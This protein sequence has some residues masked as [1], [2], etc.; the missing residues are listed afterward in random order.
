MAKLTP[1]DFAEQQR[2]YLEKQKT[3]GADVVLRNNPPDLIQPTPAQ[4]ESVGIR[5]T[6]DK[7]R[8]EAE[9]R[10]ILADMGASPSTQ[11]GINL[12]AAGAHL[13]ARG[14]DKFQG[15]ADKHDT[16]STF[17][18]RFS[19]VTELLLGNPA[20][21]L[22]RPQQALYAGAS[23]EGWDGVK[24]RL[25]PEV[26]KET[27][28]TQNDPDDNEFQSTWAQLNDMLHFGVKALMGDEGAKQGLADAL[29][30]EPV[31]MERAGQGALSIT[32][33]LDN[34]FGS[35]GATDAML[36]ALSPE[37]R[38]KVQIGLMGVDFMADPLMIAPTPASI[39]G[40]VR[41]AK[42]AA[43][44]GKAA[45]YGERADQA[46]SGAARAATSIKGDALKKAMHAVDMAGKEVARHEAKLAE[47]LAVGSVTAKDAALLAR[48]EKR[49]A[50]ADQVLRFQQEGGAKS[51]MLPEPPRRNPFSPLDEA[52]VIAQF[53]QSEIPQLRNH[54]GKGRV[55]HA[56]TSVNNAMKDPAKAPQVAKDLQQKLTPDVYNHLRT[57]GAKLPP[58]PREQALTQLWP[59]HR[60]M[61]VDD[62]A[63]GKV[64]MKFEVH[65]ATGN[66]V[67]SPDEFAKMVQYGPSPGDVNAQSAFYAQLGA[68]PSD[69]TFFDH[70]T[71]YHSRLERE[72]PA[73]GRDTRA[74]RM[75]IGS[76]SGKPGEGAARYKTVMDQFPGLAEFYKPGLSE[77]N[78]FG[79]VFNGLNHLREAR[80]AL[81]GFKNGKEIL[82]NLKT[83]S[84]NMDQEAAALREL[85]GRIAQD[86]K[87]GE[88]KGPVFK[89]RD[90]AK[91]QQIWNLLD[92]PLD[93]DVEDMSGWHK[94]FKAAYDAAPP[95]VQRAHD[96]LRSLFNEK[97]R[98]LGIPENLHITGYAPHLFDQSNLPPD[99]LL[100]GKGFAHTAA[101]KVI[102]HALDP[103]LQNK[104]G[105]STDL[106]EVMD[107]YI[108]GFSRKIHMEPAFKRADDLAMLSGSVGTANY[109]RK[110]IDNMQGKPGLLDTFVDDLAAGLTDKFKL[111]PAHRNMVA[112][113]GLL[114]SGYL[115]GNIPFLLANLG[116]ASLVNTSKFGIMSSARGLF[117]LATKEGRARAEKL[118]VMGE[119]NKLIDSVPGE[120]LWPG[121]KQ[122]HAA[123]EKANKI[124]LGQHSENIARSWAVNAYLSDL[125][126]KTGKSLVELHEAGLL[127]AAMRDALYASEELHHTYGPMGRI[128]A[129][130][131][132]GR[133][134]ESPGT[135]FLSFG[136]KSAEM[137]ADK[138]IN[139]Q[140][141]LMKYF[142]YSG[143][144]Q[145]TAASQLGL[146]VGQFTGTGFVG[147][148]LPEPDKDKILPTSVALQTWY[149]NIVASAYFTAQ[150]TGH[151]PDPAKAAEAYAK[152]RQ[153]NAKMIPFSNAVR[154]ASKTAQELDQGWRV[155]SQKRP[156]LQLGHGPKR[157]LPSILTRVP[158]A[159]Q[160]QVTQRMQTEV[161]Q[162]AQHDAALKMQL[163]DDV[164]NGMQEGDTARVQNAIAKA[165]RLG[166][167]L[168][169]DG[170]KAR[171][172]A[173]STTRLLRTFMDNPAYL[174]L[175]EE[176]RRDSAI[177][178]EQNVRRIKPTK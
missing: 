103:R 121:M 46:V 25:F 85:V 30:T 87:L 131:R 54:P 15:W 102:F 170:I 76:G 63:T 168:S 114:Y 7:V 41:F 110:L 141:M 83:G 143:A 40:K 158:S 148:M 128:P 5:P 122:A 109:T 50:V 29:D 119:F 72:V 164:Y 61:Y 130:G 136:P 157:D 27:L 13:V 144:L 134:V 67:M 57:Q 18:R 36:A 11:I 33:V 107:Y 21:W 64:L 81:P 161:R 145:R 123:A 17:G 147:Q 77:G 133:V 80:R 28:G 58:N 20:T 37:D 97:A 127:D 125:E 82:L 59:W 98:Q 146:D 169:K 166:I 84:D 163:M 89:V 65:K 4:V 140:G 35:A 79:S 32:D 126:R 93:P 138:A 31:I 120:K 3:L 112:S 69:L 159:Y 22:Q 173:L 99:L 100:A 142:A 108:H 176:A 174:K 23:G 105:Y 56:V 34:A 172:N 167:K 177:S 45:A 116:T 115:A 156:L 16:M 113:Q 132:L 19:N 1:A 6:P 91:A 48:A 49:K 86:A 129:L 60:N 111:S 24:K 139:D 55:E 117:Q 38:A 106:M 153:L 152:A 42:T 175:F 2:A 104:P 88:Y 74:E 150:M 70:I 71:P 92:M 95:D 154:N 44:L 178:Q 124:G 90:K 43:K 12:L 155:D 94:R 26:T 151:A 47:A 53:D 10:N 51:I 96:G 78:H 171:H 137:L 135:M 68:D 52:K 162:R 75:W 62:P 165:G 73:P 9:K 8:F 66:V 101:G 118:G 39:V 149:A 160:T 14:T